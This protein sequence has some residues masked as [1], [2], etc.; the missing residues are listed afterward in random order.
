M[1]LASLCLPA[2]ECKWLVSDWLVQFAISFHDQKR[3]LVTAE[4]MMCP[5]QGYS[6]GRQNVLQLSNFS[7]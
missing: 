3:V 2:V 7:V 6:R 4:C 1:G 5:Q